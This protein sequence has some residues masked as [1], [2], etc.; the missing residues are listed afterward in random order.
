MIRSFVKALVLMLLFSG[1]LWLGAPF[2]VKS[3]LTS[4]PAHKLF[5]IRIHLNGVD[6]A[7]DRLAFNGVFLTKG[8]VPVLMARR[9]V[10]LRS[11]LEEIRDKGVS[12]LVNEVRCY[13]VL[14]YPLA[15]GRGLLQSDLAFEFRP[16]AHGV[17]VLWRL[18]PGTDERNGAGPLSFSSVNGTLFWDGR[19][20]S[21]RLDFESEEIGFF[22]GDGP[23]IGVDSLMARI[24]AAKSGEEWTIHGEVESSPIFLDERSLGAVEL[25]IEGLLDQVVFH[26]AMITRDILGED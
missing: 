12:A 20:E 17:E 14:F 23:E 8:E 18:W 3:V 25:T 21:A 6:I 24:S 2:I 26:G 7:G 16:R 4:I 1:G 22:Q 5:G 11:D 15:Q 9:V 13:G 10:V 19:L